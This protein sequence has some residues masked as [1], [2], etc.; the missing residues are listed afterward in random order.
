MTFRSDTFRKRV[1]ILS[2][3]AVS[4]APTKVN[5]NITGYA[6]VVSTVATQEVLAEGPQKKGK[7]ML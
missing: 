6:T 7:A 5:L 3:T 2:C 1:H 4:F